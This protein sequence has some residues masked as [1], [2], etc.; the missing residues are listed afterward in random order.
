ME[1]AVEDPQESAR[2]AASVRDIRRR[3][4]R[5]AQERE[6]GGDIRIKVDF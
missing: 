2:T 5:Q 1:A 3:G 4:G 6:P